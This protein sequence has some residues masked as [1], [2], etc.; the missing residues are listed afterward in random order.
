M[1]ADFKTKLRRGDAVL[2]VNPDHPSPS[3]VEFM[4]RLPIDAVFID[5]EQGSADVESVENMARA[6][7]LA[8]LT[9]LVRLFDGAD[10]VIERYLCRGI[11]GIVVPRLE[12]PAQAAQVAAA[13]DY[14]CPR[15]RAAKSLI[16]QI[17]TKGALDT[18]DEFLRIP[19]IDVFFIGPVDLAKSLG[20]AGDF[21]VPAV[22]DAMVG[23]VHRI[24]AAGK[25]AGILVDRTNARDWAEQGVQFLYEHINNF[26]SAGVHSFARECGP[27]ALTSKNR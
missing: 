1:R 18:L 20:H 22:H 6:A 14:C 25:A 5:C 2:V 13:V 27:A 9:S 8:G 21:R 11:D 19:G 7:R 16:V 10:W 23:A 3:L 15:D 12:T 17:E 24:R 4:G 26:L